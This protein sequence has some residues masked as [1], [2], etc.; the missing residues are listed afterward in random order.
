MALWKPT[1]RELI[2]AAPLALG[3]AAMPAAAQILPRS[4]NTGQVASHRAPTTGRANQALDYGPSKKSV[5]LRLA[6][7]VFDNV[8]AS[9]AVFALPSVST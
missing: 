4:P 2:A 1:R 9:S 7:V 6:V 5:W 3:A 8:I